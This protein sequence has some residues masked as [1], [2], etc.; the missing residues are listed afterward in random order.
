MPTPQNIVCLVALAHTTHT[1]AVPLR[2]PHAPHGAPSANGR[3][4]FPFGFLGAGGRLPKARRGRAFVVQFFFFFTLRTAPS[5]AAAAAVAAAAS[6]VAAAAAAAAAARPGDL[7]ARKNTTSRRSRSPTTAC[8]VS[9]VPSVATRAPCLCTKRA[10]SER[11]GAY[12]SGGA[13]IKRALNGTRKK[14]VR[15]ASTHDCERKKKSTGPASGRAVRERGQASQR[16]ART[17]TIPPAPANTASGHLA[18]PDCSNA[19]CTR[20]R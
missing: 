17:P 18:L 7:T 2:P 11:N 13:Q 14:A 9:F 15:R 3:P 16:Q 10:H 19:C 20:R 6:A 8:V 5:T 4:G 1:R 12:A